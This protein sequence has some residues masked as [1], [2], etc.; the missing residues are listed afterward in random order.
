MALRLEQRAEIAREILRKHLRPGQT[1]MR[2]KVILERLEKDR[3]IG[4]VIEARLYLKSLKD[5]GEIDCIWVDR[6]GPVGQVTLNLRAP[7]QSP[8]EAAWRR[9]AQAF[10]AERSDARPGDEA[11]LGDLWPRLGDWPI[12]LAADLFAELYDLRARFEAGELA[13]LTCYRASAS[14]RLGS[15]KLLSLLPRASL[16]AFGIDIGQFAAPPPYVIVAG[17]PEPQ[18]VV[19]VE[20]PE[21]FEAAVAATPDLPV[22]WISVYGFG[23]ATIDGQGARLADVVT[24]T[25]PPIALVRSGAPPSID[26]LLG[27]P[28]L[29]HWGDLDRTGLLIFQAMRSARPQLRLSALYGPMLAVIRSGGGHPYA[30]V[31]GKPRQ[32]CWMA[33]DHLLGELL[34]DCEVRAIDQEHLSK[35][36]ICSLCALALGEFISASG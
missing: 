6:L 31:A 21:A 26:Q 16:Q 1:T 34:N 30:E 28:R 27:H 15:S 23:I 19:L 2:D 33:G 18:A 4:S 35:D 12:S 7:A 8:L 11:A 17:P 24:S 36:D 20:N 13:G 3:R 22:A 9:E 14:G 10:V 25:T 5:L 32:D 29:F